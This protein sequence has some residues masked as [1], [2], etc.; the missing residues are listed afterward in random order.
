M[1]GCCR[2]AWACES[3]NAVLCQALKGS[4]GP[5]RRTTAGFP[6][7][8]AGGMLPHGMP[9]DAQ[10]AQQVAMP[11][12]S[13]TASSVP[14]AVVGESGAGSMA[15]SVAAGARRPLNHEPGPLQEFLRLHSAFNEPRAR[16]MNIR[17]RGPSGR[18]GLPALPHPCYRQSAAVAHVC[19]TAGHPCRTRRACCGGTAT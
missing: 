4:R 1:E 3:V 15:A 16:A 8:E 13:T 6:A 5:S 7:P 17:V 12:T 9:Y 19:V 14:V 2:I 11:A 18:A 10:Q